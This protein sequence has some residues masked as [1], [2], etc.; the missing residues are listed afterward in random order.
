MKRRSAYSEYLTFEY[1]L[2][3]RKAQELQSPWLLKRFSTEDKAFNVTRKCLKRSMKFEKRSPSRW[4]TL[5]KPNA[6]WSSFFFQFWRAK[7]LKRFWLFKNNPKNNSWRHRS[8]FL[9]FT[10]NRDPVKVYAILN[11]LFEKPTSV[12]R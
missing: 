9:E 5:A 4:E 11:N 3:N 6:N 7:I 8:H 1:V 10:M 2:K 12:V